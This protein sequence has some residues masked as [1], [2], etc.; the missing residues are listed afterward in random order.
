MKAPVHAVASA[1]PLGLVLCLAAPA[2]GAPSPAEEI[3][4][5]AGKSVVIDYPED[6]ARISTSSPEIVDY[7][8]VSSREILLH[9]KNAGMATLV[10][11]AKSGQRNFY[12]ITVEQNLEPIRKLIRES[13]PREQI[14]VL[15]ARDSISLNGEVSS[16][17]IAE[18]CTALVTPVAKSVINNLRVKTQPDKQILLRVKFAEI[19]RTVVQNLGVNLV[20]TGA[21]NTPGQ[22]TTGQ[23]SSLRATELR[24]VIP[25]GVA[26]TES[27]FTI[28]DALNIFAFRP[29]LNLAAFIKALQQQGMLQILAE[30]NLVTSNGKEASFL[31]GGEFPVPIL[32]GGAN[33]GAVTVQFREFGIRLSFK[34]ELTE[35]GT[36]R[37]DVRPEVSTVDMTNAVSLSGFTIPALAT[38]RIESTIELGPGQSF[39][40]GGLIDD[41]ATEQFSRMP[42]LASIPVLGALFRSKTEQRSKA[43]LVV[44]V[45][46]ETVE[47]LP[48]SDP[49][50]LPALPKTRIEPMLYPEG[51]PVGTKAGAGAKRAPAKTRQE[52]YATEGEV[53]KKK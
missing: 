1:I 17:A 38:R 44:M 20:S 23:F 22:T 8:P 2:I 7:V 26:G 29:D 39:V 34:P 36:L 49:A 12:N 48:A 27:K 47:P 31:V 28:T 11:W 41:R 50:V 9:A 35:N 14:T 40:I 53:K 42:G 3:R 18:R 43:E 33:A 24:G 37:M 46:P 52:V 45:T 51:L 30:P 21:L 6:V 5:F 4:I 32:Q 10:V 13:F 19:N 15:A 16:Q 25:G